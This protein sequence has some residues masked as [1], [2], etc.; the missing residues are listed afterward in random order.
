MQKRKADEGESE[1]KKKKKRSSGSDA[2]N[3]FR[4]TGNAKTRVGVKRQQL[5]VE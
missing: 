1:G 5:E 3:F 4:G 2:L